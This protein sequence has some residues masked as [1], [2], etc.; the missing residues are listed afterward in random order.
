SGTPRQ[1]QP[2]RLPPGR[3]GLFRRFFQA[4]R[5]QKTGN[6]RADGHQV[7]RV[8]H[9][10]F[11]FGQAGGADAR[12]NLG[13]G[14][15][16]HAEQVGQRQAAQR[17]RAGAAQCN[18]V[19][20]GFTTLQRVVEGDFVGSGF[21][22]LGHDEL[23]GIKK[24]CRVTGSQGWK[25]VYRPI[26]ARCAAARSSPLTINS[27]PGTSILITSVDRKIVVYGMLVL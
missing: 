22:C 4:F 13:K 19:N 7:G 25:S 17:T 2:W 1:Y 6:L 15:G 11:L 3:A 5:Y 10:Y 16:V 24:G 12:N 8:E 18:G 9:A 14:V 21:G 26:A 20:S 27:M 23:P